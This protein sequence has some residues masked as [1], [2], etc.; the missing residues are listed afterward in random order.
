VEQGFFD[1]VASEAEDFAADV[2]KRTLALENPPTSDI[3]AH[4]F[5]ED[6]PVVSDQAAWLENYL[7]SFEQGAS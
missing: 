4:V 7:S 1:S 2:R 5:S 3:F 6:H